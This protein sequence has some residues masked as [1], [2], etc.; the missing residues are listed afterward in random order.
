MADIPLFA[1]RPLSRNRAR[2]YSVAAEVFQDLPDNSVQPGAWAN[3]PA[4]NY[5]SCL[6]QAGS[7]NAEPKRNLVPARQ[8]MFETVI[9]LDGKETSNASQ[10]GP[11]SVLMRERISGT[12]I[13]ETES[14]VPPRRFATRWL[15]RLCL[16]L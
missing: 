5:V 12:S 15:L 13:A 8:R 2:C 11:R 16:V 9:E 4:L 3:N 1:D 10:G 14:L 7:D 6:L